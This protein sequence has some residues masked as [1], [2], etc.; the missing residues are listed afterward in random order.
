MR[1]LAH[2]GGGVNRI[3]AVRD[4]GDVKHRILIFQRIEAGVVAE[5]PFGAQLVEIHVTFKHDLR[6]GGNFQVD[7][8]ALHQFDRLLRAGIRRS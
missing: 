4:A 5:W 3:L 2:D 6:R 1:R 7:G 8:L